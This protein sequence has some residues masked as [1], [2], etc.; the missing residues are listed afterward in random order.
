MTS[1]I[2]WTGIVRLG[3]VNAALGAVVALTTF[4][5]N[6]I[7]VVE[8]ALPALVPGALVALHYAVQLARPRLGFGSDIGGRRTPWIVGGLAV[9]ALGGAAAA[10]ATLVI[11]AHRWLG[12][13]L[14]VPAFAMVGAGVG[15][16]GTSSLALLAT[17]VAP[18]RR[19]AAATIFWLLMIFG[20]VAA[21]GLAGGLL[22]PFS[23]PRLLLVACC[24]AAGAFLLGVTAIWG[25]ENASHASAAPVRPTGGFAAALADIWRERQA[26]RFA[27]FVF[28]S[29]LAYSGQE[30]ILEPFAGAVFGLG[31]ARTAS[32][33]GLHQSGL[34][35]GMLLVAIAG[36][37]AGSGRAATLRRWTAGGCLASATALLGLATACFV[38]P[39][40][41]LAPNVLLL[42]VANGAFAVSA[43]GAMMGLAAAG[44]GTRAGTR[45]GVW[46]AAQAVAM[47]AGG[48]LSSGASD[49]GR[50]LLG[51]PGTSYAAVFSG[52]ALL[53][54]AAAALAGGVFRTEGQDLPAGQA[55]TA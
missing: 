36:S 43:I 6:R 1:F 5:L 10:G 35:G 40:W 31:P 45:L 51:T 20:A 44:R 16:V 13:A 48:L 29:M 42:G 27:L 38:G 47:G 33:S 54:L 14:A 19:P 4:T 22:H 55:A 25:L 53:F 41:P 2:G 17:H 34:L 7:M 32:L 49:L 39:A 8:L 50:A 30:L 11:A 12:I 9:L 18:A 21:A 23:L 37:L 3:L 15:S 24:I 46:G 26:R 28:V 52:E